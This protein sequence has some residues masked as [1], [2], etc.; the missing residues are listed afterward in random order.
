MINYECSLD[1]LAPRTDL[2]SLAEGNITSN[3]D[4]LTSMALL[5]SASANDRQ[6]LPPGD[7]KFDID[8]SVG[9]RTLAVDITFTLKLRDPCTVSDMVSLTWAA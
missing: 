7:Y 4:N 5:F 6:I 8:A 9:D 1:S 3:F 2:C